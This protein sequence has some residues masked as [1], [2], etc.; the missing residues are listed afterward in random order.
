MAMDTYTLGITS[1]QSQESKGAGAES[2]DRG[3]TSDISP[4]TVASVSRTQP[5]GHT[6]ADTT[7]HVSSDNRMHKGRAPEAP[8]W[9]LERPVIDATLCDRDCGKEYHLFMGRKA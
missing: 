3:T 9:D 1:P 6:T 4:V 7:D 8:V 2:S 5:G